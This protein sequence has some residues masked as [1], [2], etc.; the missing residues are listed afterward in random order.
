MDQTFAMQVRQGGAQTPDQR[1]SLL[2]LGRR[3]RL[4][5]WRDVLTQR[6]AFDKLHRIPRDAI[7]QAAIQDADDAWVLNSGERLDLAPDSRQEAL[8]RRVHRLDGRDAAGPQVSSP[9][10]GAHG[11]CVDLVEDLIRAEVPAAPAIR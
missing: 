7:R 11:S 10:N 5:G 1:E 3:A 9:V 2:Q 4:T 6:H 8:P